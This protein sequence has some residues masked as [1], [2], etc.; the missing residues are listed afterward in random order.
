MGSYKVQLINSIKPRLLEVNSKRGVDTLYLLA[1]DDG[2]PSV[3]DKG[4]PENSTFVFL[5][6]PPSAPF[7]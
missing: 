1:T 3:T 5:S 4:N 2:E 6:P 7:C